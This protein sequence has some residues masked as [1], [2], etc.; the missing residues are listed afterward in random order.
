MWLRIYAE[1]SGQRPEP[2]WHADVRCV[3]SWR[4][5]VPGHRKSSLSTASLSTSVSAERA[6]P[7]RHCLNNFSHRPGA[8]A[9][10]PIQHPCQRKRPAQRQDSQ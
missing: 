9:I 10:V 1:Y 3:V 2:H 5:A 7:R 6:V 8:P 4:V